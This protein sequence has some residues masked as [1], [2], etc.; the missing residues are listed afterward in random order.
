MSDLTQRRLK[1]LFSYDPETGLFVDKVHN[2]IKVGTLNSKGYLKIRA[3]GKI[4]SAHRLAWL[5]EYGCFPPQLTDHINHDRADNRIC[6]L[7]LVSD[8]ENQKNSK[9]RSDN[10]SGV[11]GVMFDKNRRKWWVR[12]KNNKKNTHIGYSEDFFEACCMRKSAEKR[13]GFHPN[14]GSRT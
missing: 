1:E 9:L 4:Y 13:L 6:N 8:L 5:Y 12:I 3:D 14:N 11:P 7:R 10:K 2:R